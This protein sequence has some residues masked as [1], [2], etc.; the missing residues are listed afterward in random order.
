[1]CFNIHTRAPANNSNYIAKCTFLGDKCDVSIKLD[2]FPPPLRWTWNVYTRIFWKFVRKNFKQRNKISSNDEMWSR[3][4][5]IRDSK[6]FSETKNFSPSNITL[7]I[8]DSSFCYEFWNGGH[9]RE[10]LISGT[11][12]VPTTKNIFRKLFLSYIREFKIKWRKIAEENRF[13]KTKIHIYIN[14]DEFR[15]LR[16][17][18][19]SSRLFRRIFYSKRIKIRRFYTIVN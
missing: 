18:D 9:E 15:F 10:K 11:A 17:I 3:T 16:V 13:F 12:H 4:S 8:F 7:E 19:S 14:L 1:M 5:K 6:V 2:L